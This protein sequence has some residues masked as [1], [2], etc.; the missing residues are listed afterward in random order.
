[1]DATA[2]RHR[3][4]RT[5]A[6]LVSPAL[7]DLRGPADSLE[8]AGAG[9]GSGIQ[10][11]LLGRRNDGDLFFPGARLALG[12]L[13]P[14]GPRGARAPGASP[15][16]GRDFWS[17]CEQ[18]SAS[19]LRWAKATGASADRGVV[20]SGWRDPA[21]WKQTG[22]EVG[23]HKAAL[24]INF[25][26]ALAICAALAVPYEW[27][28]RRSFRF[29]LRS[30]LA[31]FVVAAAVF[32]YFRWQADQRSR[33]EAVIE[34]I[35]RA[36]FSVSSRYWG[37][38]GSPGW[39]ARSTLASCTARTRLAAPL[40]RRRQQAA[41]ACSRVV[42]VLCRAASRESPQ[43][44]Y[45]GD[46]VHGAAQWERL[47]EMR[48]VEELGVDRPPIS[49]AEMACLAKLPKLRVLRIDKLDEA[50]LAACRRP[51]RNAPLSTISNLSGGRLIPAP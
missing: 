38:S 7:F 29:S 20:R 36:G 9:G 19:S 5:A 11:H 12:P 35:Q 44:R 34:Q 13:G 6:P 51:C 16:L 30:L 4:T 22:A 39:W 33:E 8:R 3:L 46:R 27:W 50:S 17:L 25:L 47:A 37:P 24:A 1:M 48:N 18:R 26:V 28:R 2:I 40:C 49:D 41:G 21:S 23:V 10:R 15:C 43:S 45:R 31:L 14:R 32:G 42:R